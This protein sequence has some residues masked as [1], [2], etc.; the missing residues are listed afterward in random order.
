V[1]QNEFNIMFRNAYFYWR[2]GW[3]SNPRWYRYHAGFQ[4]RCIQPLC[5]L[6]KRQNRSL[7]RLFNTTLRG[8]RSARRN[9]LPQPCPS[10]TELMRRGLV[11]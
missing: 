6:S 10:L 1:A 11:H 7:L 4:D 3:D 8:V 5:H 2:R 9:T